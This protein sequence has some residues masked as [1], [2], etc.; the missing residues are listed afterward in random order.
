MVDPPPLT[1]TGLGGHRVR[2]GDLV[3]CDLIGS[4]FPV[5]EDI[6]AD[7]EFDTGTSMFV[8]ANGARVGCVS[9]VVAVEQ[10]TSQS[11][12]LWWQESF[13]TAGRGQAVLPYGMNLSVGGARCE[14]TQQHMK[15][16]VGGQGF[17]ISRGGYTT[18]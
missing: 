12:G 2:G 9:D 18:F 15:C 1:R 17:T 13:G 4:T 8:D 5:P 10:A 14:S 3:R 7:C 11:S 6:S 16:T